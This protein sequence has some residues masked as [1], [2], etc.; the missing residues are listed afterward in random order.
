MVIL[1]ILLA[2][3]TVITISSSHSLSRLRR[4][5]LSLEQRQAARTGADGST[6]AANDSAGVPPVPAAESPVS[7]R[8]DS[9]VR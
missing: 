4:E 2:L 8:P 1:L 3:F 5:V 9:P 6:N 7:S